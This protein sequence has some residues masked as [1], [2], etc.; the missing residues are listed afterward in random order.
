MAFGGYRVIDKVTITQEDFNALSNIIA[1]K[2]KAE[3]KASETRILENN[4][5]EIEASR[6]R[7]KQDFE[8]DLEDFNSRVARKTEELT[9]GLADQKIDYDARFV[10][11]A[12]QFGTADQNVII[13]V[14]KQLKNQANADRIARSKLLETVEGNNRTLRGLVDDVAG[15]A[16]RGLDTALGVLDKAGPLFDLLGIIDTF[17]TH[18]RLNRIEA[19][20]NERLDSINQ[21]LNGMQDIILSAIERIKSELGNELASIDQKTSPI[22]SIAGSFDS[23]RDSVSDN[24]RQIGRIEQSIE[25][26][27][28][29]TDE[30]LD[31]NQNISRV[32]KLVPDIDKDT[33]HLPEVR[34]LTELI[35]NI[36]Q[37]V[38]EGMPPAV[39]QALNSDCW[40]FNGDSGLT[41]EEK[42]ALEILLERTKR[43][44]EI[45]GIW[46]YDCDTIQ[47]P[48][49]M[50]TTISE[51]A[52]YVTCS[53]AIRKKN[54]DDSEGE[55]EDETTLDDVLEAIENQPEPTLYVPESW[56]Y[57]V[58]GDRPQ[59]I[60]G[61]HKTED[62]GKKGVSKWS[63][64]IPYPTDAAIAMSW[65]ELSQYFPDYS[66]GAHQATLNLT[67]NS[68]VSARA[69][70]K[71]GA[72]AFLDRVIPLID[73]RVVPAV[74][75]D[76]EV[77]PDEETSDDSVKEVN[78]NP[79]GYI[80][81]ENS[82]FK[83]V[84]V[85]CRSL[86]YYEMGRKKGEKPTKR[87]YPPA[88]SEEEEGGDASGGTS[89]TASDNQSSSSSGAGGSGDGGR[90]I[91]DQISDAIDDVGTAGDNFSDAVIG[92]N[93][94]L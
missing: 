80:Y 74:T 16:R 26:L 15:V 9:Q 49:T 19:A 71:A 43:F 86:G 27:S 68:R 69:D 14:N 31:L 24:A 91:G 53:S 81:S 50:W 32:V 20:L 61:F 57:K 83:T 73:P 25:G 70:S 92:A 51:V 22:P 48:D 34:R 94:N 23:L 13:E 93:P 67:D 1:E 36:T 85:T 77:D 28:S 88:E 84:P 75:S 64:T 59:L 38:L 60:I 89:S 30:V 65:G 58:A 63:V 2:R 21:E 47:P 3:I 8:V 72:K 37:I 33:S 52:Q 79:R 10:E 44:G 46:P 78:D 5:A 40:E 42:R 55:E 18:I 6:A 56:P 66:R 76:V 7:I 29:K 12:R 11:Q 90:N 4:N 17:A 41:E 45:F 35:P 82:R 39:C 62:V 54:G 87:W